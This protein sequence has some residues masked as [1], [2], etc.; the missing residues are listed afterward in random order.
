MIEKLTTLLESK[1][2]TKLREEFIEMNPADAAAFIE[3]MFEE[4]AEE[5]ELIILFR[6]MPKDLAADCFAFLES[7]TQ[8]LLISYFT[9]SELREVLEQSFIDDTVDMI[10]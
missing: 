3:E 4:R 8:Q 2:Y 7:D 9:D 5:K 6:L 1:S 10:E